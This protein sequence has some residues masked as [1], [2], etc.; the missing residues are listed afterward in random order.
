MIIVGRVE[1]PAGIY[2]GIANDQGVVVLGR[3]V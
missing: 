1:P 2:V 3:A